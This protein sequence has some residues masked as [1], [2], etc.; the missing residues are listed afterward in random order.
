MPSEK[1]NRILIIC[2]HPEDTAPGQRLKY[3]QYFG[4]FRQAGFDV[5]VKSF[6]SVRFQNIVYKKGNLLAKVFW[7]L[8]GYVHRL[9]QAFTLRRYD[10]VYIF[11]WVTPF[12]PPFFERLYRGLSKKVIYDIDDMIYVKA[13]NSP[14]PRV[15]WLKGKTKPIYMFKNADYVLTST[16]A[17]E[18]FAKKYNKN[19]INIPVTV[20]TDKYTPK[21]RYDSEKIILGWSGSVSTSPYLHLLDPVLLELRKK[22]D[23]KLLVMGDENFRIEG[24]DIEA[25][26]WKEEYEVSTIRRFDIG[27]YPLP[28]DSW[29]HGKGGGKALQ[30]MAAGVPTVATA[31]GANFKIIEQGVSGFLVKTDDEWLAC[32]EK[33]MNDEMLRKQIGQKGVQVVREHFSVHA[34]KEV[35]LSVLRSSLHFSGAVSG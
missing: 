3:E 8:S 2:P 30:Y 34:N 18:E 10:I 32:L 15:A 20:N 9:L 31:V 24:L 19:V 1:R 23:Y 25:I 29:V 13:P 28:V 6:M 27:L 22:Y 26:P 21:D 11:L 35:Y 14:N 33:L 17:I 4:Y 16:P 12:G 5:E 7:T